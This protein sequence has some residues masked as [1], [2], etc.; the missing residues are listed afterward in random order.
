MQASWGI[1]QI[2]KEPPTTMQLLVSRSPNIIDWSIGGFNPAETTR[3]I[4]DHPIPMAGTRH[5][6]FGTISQATVGK[7]RGA[8]SG[9]A[10]ESP[11][12]V[13]IYAHSSTAIDI[14]PHLAYPTGWQLIPKN[15]PEPTQR[16]IVQ[17]SFTLLL[18]SNIQML[19]D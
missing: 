1:K 10:S 19:A 15:P 9:F 2:K 17:I 8:N 5:T 3:V 13:S 11:I 6:V 12:S 7:T 18:A 16:Q 14:M 4:G